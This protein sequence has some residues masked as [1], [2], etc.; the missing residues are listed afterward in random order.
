MPTFNGY[1]SDFVV[2]DDL[3]IDRNIANIPSG[4]MIDTAWFTVRFYERSITPIFQ[5]TIS[6]ILSSAGIVGNTV[7]GVCQV[8]F[9][10]TGTDTALLEP[11][12]DLFYDLQI[13]TDA[14]KFYT[15]EKGRINGKVQITT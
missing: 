10:L 14:N 11:D 5:K 13:K 3:D 12:N 9:T 15:P 1:I 7:S 4:Q 8:T 2:G 6:G